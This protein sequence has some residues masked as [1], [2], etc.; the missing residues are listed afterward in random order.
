MLCGMFVGKF[1]TFFL[2]LSL[3]RRKIVKVRKKKIAKHLTVLSRT[4]QIFYFIQN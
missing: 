1:G 2:S 3:K 4:S